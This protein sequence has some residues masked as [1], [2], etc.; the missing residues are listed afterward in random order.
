M[1]LD[2]ECPRCGRRCGNGGSGFTVRCMCGWAGGLS[3]EDEAHMLE[4]IERHKQR[5]GEGGDTE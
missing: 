1:F 5:N 2:R 4:F 3:P